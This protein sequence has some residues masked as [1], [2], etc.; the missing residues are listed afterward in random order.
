MSNSGFPISIR[1]RAP[2][3]KEDC[4]MALATELLGD[5]W[6][7][8]ILREA[9]YGVARYDDMLAD[10][11]APRSTL[12]DRL[13][14]MVERGLLTRQPYQEA[15]SRVRYGYVLSEAGFALG[16]T[17]IAL[18]EWGDDHVL[19]T[20][21]PVQFVDSESGKP[22]RVELVNDDGEIVSLTDTEIKL[23]KTQRK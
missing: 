12:T 8:L 19:E 10:I 20:E 9:F 11:G 2:V 15:G 23:K 4:P 5:R 18:S 3:P 13:A 6:I 1:R 16:K 22:L 21:N 17:L 14:K 7:M